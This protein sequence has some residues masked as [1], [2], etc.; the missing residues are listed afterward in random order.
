MGGQGGIREASRHVWIVGW[1]EPNTHT[2]FIDHVFGD[3]PATFVHHINRVGQHHIYGILG[4]EITKYTVTYGVYIRSHMVRI[5]GHIRCVYT[6]LAN[7][8]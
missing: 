4:R 7:P 5:Y 1:P 3:L 2:V 6:V 8:T